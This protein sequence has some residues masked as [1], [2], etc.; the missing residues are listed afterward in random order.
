MFGQSKMGSVLVIVADEF[1]QDTFQVPLI[2]NYD[3]AEQIAP[4]ATHEA[5]GHTNFATGS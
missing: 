3:V 2:E 5:L 4:A 1:G